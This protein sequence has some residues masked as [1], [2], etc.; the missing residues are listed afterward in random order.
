M[1]ANIIRIILESRSYNNWIKSMLFHANVA[2]YVFNKPVLILINI[3]YI[4]P[5]AYYTGVTMMSTSNLNKDLDKFGQ[6]FVK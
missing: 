5:R 4:L 6:L 3:A 2:E 1:S